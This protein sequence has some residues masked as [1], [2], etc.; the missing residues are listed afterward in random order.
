[1]VELVLSLPVC[2]RQVCTKTLGVRFVHEADRRDKSISLCLEME[3]NQN[4]FHGGGIVRSQEGR[5][6]TDWRRVGPRSIFGAYHGAFAE[7]LMARQTS[8]SNEGASFVDATRTMLFFPCRLR[9]TMRLLDNTST[10]WYQWSR[11]GNLCI[12]RWLR[13]LIGGCKLVVRAS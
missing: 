3:W 1:M 12:Y 2:Y 10:L 5:K 13:S 9:T 6:L 7:K 8:E 4:G 11:T